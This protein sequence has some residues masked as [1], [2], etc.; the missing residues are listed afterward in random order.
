MM[1]DRQIAETLESIDK[2]VESLVNA[3]NRAER[4]AEARGKPL[5]DYEQITSRKIR[6]RKGKR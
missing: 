6:R 5:Y 3:R 2:S 4:R 1:Q